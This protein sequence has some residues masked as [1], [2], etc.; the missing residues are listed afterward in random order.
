MKERILEG[1]LGEGGLLRVRAVLAMAM[2][3]G[4]MVLL[5]EGTLETEQAF[6]LIF[7]GAGAYAIQR[8]AKGG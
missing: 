1:L 5:A 3:I 2:V 7:G 4:S 6:T 8:G